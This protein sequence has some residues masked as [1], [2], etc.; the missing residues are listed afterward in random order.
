[1]YQPCH[2]V[3]YW[4][5]SGL[6]ESLEEIWRFSEMQSLSNL[7]FVLS[8]KE[9]V[10]GIAIRKKYIFFSVRTDSQSEIRPFSENLHVPQELS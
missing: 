3:F 10:L 9:L 6:Y 4:F 7:Q 8:D 1:M 5:A 2:S